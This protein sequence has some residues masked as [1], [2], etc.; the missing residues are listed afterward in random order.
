MSISTV[1]GW[2]IFDGKGRP[3]RSGISFNSENEAWCCYFC[4][5]SGWERMR[6]Y[7]ITEGYK[8]LPVTLSVIK[9]E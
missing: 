9:G 5:R 3:M 7:A 4:N 6:D 8:C 1:S 2:A